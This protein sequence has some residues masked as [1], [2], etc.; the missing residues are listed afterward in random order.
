ML[1]LAKAP[2]L[3]SAATLL[4]LATISGCGTSPEEQAAQVA[5]RRRI[6]DQ[7]AQR[8]AERVAALEG[9][10]ESRRKA[11]ESPPESGNDPG[12]QIMRCQGL[13]PVPFTLGAPIPAVGTVICG[14]SDL[15]Q[16]VLAY[17]RWY[18]GTANNEC[19]FAR[20]VNG[21]P[22]LDWGFTQSTQINFGVR[23]STGIANISL[24]PF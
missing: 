10:A 7:E 18:C 15:G 22:T 21:R 23:L 6:A 13:S 12:H 5:E 4:M 16:K 19:I 3:A 17:R 1:Q 9:N 14:N 11:G 20:W 24:S 8:R 2:H